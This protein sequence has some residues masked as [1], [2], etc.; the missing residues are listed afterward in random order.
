MWTRKMVSGVPKKSMNRGR[1]YS[2]V[3]YDRTM[4]SLMRYTA[5]QCWAWGFR[6]NFGDPIDGELAERHPISP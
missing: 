5:E 1:T 2:V 6:V 3:D 4:R